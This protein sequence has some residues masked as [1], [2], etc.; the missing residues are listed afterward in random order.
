MSGR[1]CRLSAPG[2]SAL[3]LWRL[4][5]AEADLARVLGL[6]RLPQVGPPRRFDL[7][8]AGQVLD[9]GLL[10]LRRG[11]AAAVAEL[12]LHGGA[13]V[14]EALRR[15]LGAAGWVEDSLAEDS[16]RQR[17][18]RA[19]SPLA[20]RAAGAVLDGR[21]DR[22][23]EAIA[24]LPGAARPAAAAGLLA[25]EAWARILEQPP[26]VALVGPP[27]AGKS[28]LFNAWLQE[29][30]VTVSP[31]P[32]TTRDAVEASVL[33]GR[34]TD[35]F[36]IRL[37]DTAGLWGGAEG[38]DA[39]AVRDSRR[40]L[41]QAW[42]RIWV[43]DTAVPPSSAFVPLFQQRAEEDLV[44]LH[45]SDLAPGWQPPSGLGWLRGSVLRE[46]SGLVR[47]LESALSLRFG[48]PPGPA[49]LLPFGAERRSRLHAMLG[50]A[51]GQR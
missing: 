32:G 30:R 46:G 5:A 28:T 36:E 18:Y 10:W 29:E 24:D 7:A 19:R 35:A 45:R 17:F 50:A 44:L 15:T 8:S 33:L 27:N 9:Q 37:V 51:A 23:L 31:H 40:V 43:L 49:V 4:E 16:D 12:H 20:A 34:G 14:A 47:D 21:L 3:S 13:G 26:V 22:A 2:P 48:R 41:R 25:G 6:G 38:V 39:A 42:T 11:G 1:Y